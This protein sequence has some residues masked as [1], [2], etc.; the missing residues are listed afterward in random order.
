VS[1]PTASSLPHSID[2]LVITPAGE[3]R[4]HSVPA[5]ESRLITASNV[6]QA[7]Y[8]LIGCSSVDVVRLTPEIDMWVDDEGLVKAHPPR[9][10]QVASY[11]ATRFGFPFQL[12]AGTA[13]FSGGADKA[14]YTLPLSAA[15]RQALTDLVDE[16]HGISGR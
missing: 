5:G 2:L 7:L 8:E 15:A 12:Y 9:I 4:D 16:L 13:V 1:S 10:N 6:L 14:G 11:I 3:L